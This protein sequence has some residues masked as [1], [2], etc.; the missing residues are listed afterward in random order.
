MTKKF[1]LVRQRGLRGAV[2]RMNGALHAAGRDFDNTELIEAL[3]QKMFGEDW[4]RPPSP[5][6]AG[7]EVSGGQTVREWGT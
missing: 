4:R 7:P 1:V 5:E 3:G 2:E 6:P